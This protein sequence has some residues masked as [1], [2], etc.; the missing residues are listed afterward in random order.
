MANRERDAA[1]EQRWR[2]A[3]GRFTASGLSVREFCRR[4]ELTE[5][6]FY[7]WRRT[8]AAREARSAPKSRRYSPAPAF[9][10]AVVTAAPSDTTIALELA[11]GCVL[12]FAGPTASEQL[13]DLIVALQARGAR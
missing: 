11:G 12:R 10:P 2:E 8:L 6:A 5:S 3:L 4:E 9:V 13:A 1:K 7:A